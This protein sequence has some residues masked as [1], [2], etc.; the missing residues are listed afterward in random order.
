MPEPGSKRRILEIGPGRRPMHHRSQE[1]LQIDPDQEEYTALDQ[2][3]NKF[4]AAV[5][6]AAKEKY[7]ASIKLVHGDRANLIGVDNESIHELVALGSHGEDDPNMVKEFDRVLQPGGLLCLGVG[8]NFEQQLL[9]TLGQQLRTRGYDVLQ[10]ERLEYNYFPS[11]DA[12]HNPYVVI[13]FKKPS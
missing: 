7:G 4:E 1:G 11:V 3:I 2:P 10:T 6:A 9:L 5:W 12:P 8:K 13:T